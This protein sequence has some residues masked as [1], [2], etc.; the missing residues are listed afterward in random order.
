MDA[1]EATGN[2]WCVDSMLVME[3]RKMRHMSSFLTRKKQVQKKLHRTTC[4]YQENGEG[5]GS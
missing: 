1:G 5:P 4:I 3:N 2:R